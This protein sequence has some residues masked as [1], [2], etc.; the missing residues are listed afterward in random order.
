MCRKKAWLCKACVKG[1]NPWYLYMYIM[2]KQIL[3]VYQLN[4]TSISYIIYILWKPFKWKSIKMV[5]FPQIHNKTDIWLTQGNLRNNMNYINI[6]VHLRQVF[7]KLRNHSI[8]SSTV[9]INI[10]YILPLRYWIIILDRQGM[11]Q[12]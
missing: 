12:L 11:S 6:I 3:L 2:I 1:D 7:G 9:F 8:H 5:F 10:L 4:I